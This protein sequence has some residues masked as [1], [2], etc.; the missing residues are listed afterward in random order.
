MRDEAAFVEILRSLAPVDH[1]WVF[2]RGYD[3]PGEV[4]GDGSGRG[5]MAFLGG[6]VL[7]R[8]VVVG[9]GMCCS[10]TRQK[11]NLV[12]RVPSSW[13]SRISYIS[14]DIQFV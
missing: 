14:L 9:K 13:V 12:D 3:Y 5:E 6:E 7:G 4:G 10:N 8:A 2:K 1:V 11:V